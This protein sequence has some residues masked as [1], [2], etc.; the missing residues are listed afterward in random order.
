M[1]KDTGRFI[2][3]GHRAHH[4]V[5]D[6]VHKVIATGGPGLPHH[7]DTGGSMAEG[8]GALAIPARTVVAIAGARPV[9]YGRLPGLLFPILPPA[10]NT[11]CA[12]R[13]F[14]SLSKGY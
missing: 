5:D 9:Q 2:I 8:K 12:T 4:L 7:D 10:V 14:P 13:I 1:R 11:L 6:I 3:S